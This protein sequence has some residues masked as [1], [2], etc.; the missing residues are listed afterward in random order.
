M[1]KFTNI[2]DLVVGIN[3]VYPGSGYIEIFDGK[4]FLISSTG[5]IGYAEFNDDILKF[6][7]IKSNI[8]TFLP[9]Q[10][11]IKHGGVSI[12]DMKFINNKIYISFTDEIKKI[13]GQCQY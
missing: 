4:L 11:L 3:L 10:L 12:K 7:Q 13:V 9:R 8:N 6:D 2:N 1:K 5:T